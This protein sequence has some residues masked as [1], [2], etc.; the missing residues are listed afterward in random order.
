MRV[1]LKFGYDGRKYHGFARQPNL[2]T[3]EEC[4]EKIPELFERFMHRY[5]SIKHCYFPTK[6]F[7][8]VKFFDFTSTTVES[9]F[10]KQLS[11]RNFRALIET[12]YERKR[13]PVRLL[14]IGVHLSNAKSLQLT[15]W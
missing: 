1:A 14:G 7:V 13:L 4:N 10:Y 12:G 11:V 6:L 2:E 3:I 5:E 8:K 15:F 9:G